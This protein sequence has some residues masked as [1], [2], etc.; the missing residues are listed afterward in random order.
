[1]QNCENLQVGKKVL[2]VTIQEIR[3]NPVL[4]IIIAKL[5]KI[6]RNYAARDTGKVAIRP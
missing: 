3:P 5:V 4:K 2:S 6:T 1:M